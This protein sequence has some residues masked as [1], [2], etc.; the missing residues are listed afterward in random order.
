MPAKNI[1]ENTRFYIVKNG[2]FEVVV[3]NR[4]SKH[5]VA[6]SSSL[7]DI[8]KVFKKFVDNRKS[9]ATAYRKVLKK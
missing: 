1:L 8:K 7:E 4:E 6:S 3:D 9:L 2:Q 5:V